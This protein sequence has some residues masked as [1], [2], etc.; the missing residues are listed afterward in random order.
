MTARTVR[1]VK[2]KTS[3]PRSRACATIVGASGAVG[4]ETEDDDIRLYGGE[5]EDHARALRQPLGNPPGVGVV[6]RQAVEMMVECVDAGRAENARL[7]HRTARHA[8]V[9]YRPVDQRARTGEQRAAGRAQS[10]GQRDRDQIERRGERRA[11]APARHRSVPKP[12]AVE[13]TRHVAFARGCAQALDFALVEDDAAGAI[14]GVLDF[15]QR[16]RRIDRMTA[17][18]HRRDEFGDAE[19]AAGADFG[20]LHAGVGGRRAGLVPDGVALAA[21][22]DVVARP[23]QHAQRNL[24]RHRAAGQPERRLLAEQARDA[25]LQRIDRRVLA[26]LVVADGRGGDGGAHLRRR[27]GH[28]VRAKVDRRRAGGDAAAGAGLRVNPAHRWKSRQD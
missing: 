13:K 10:L 3:T 19:D 25:L 16:R 15:D 22:D 21:D 12:R 27:P 28:G 7:A 14:V 20:E 8:P 11:G 23:G 26:V 6:I 5:V 24:V 17:R 9:A 18:F 2:A 1:G 4:R